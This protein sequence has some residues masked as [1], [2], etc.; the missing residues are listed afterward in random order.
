MWKLKE[1][2]ET[3]D[4]QIGM[5]VRLLVVS[6]HLATR[7]ERILPS[8][9]RRKHRTKAGAWGVI[10]VLEVRLRYQALGRAPRSSSSLV[11]RG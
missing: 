9:L 6:G 5:N 8:A 4:R 2:R 10:R 1:C 11:G 7:S 3:A